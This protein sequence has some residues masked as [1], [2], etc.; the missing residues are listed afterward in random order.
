MSDTNQRAKR[1][2]SSGK[3]SFQMS[4]LY[5]NAV[6]SIRGDGESEH[7]SID[8]MATFFSISELSVSLSI[9]VVV[10]VVVV[11][12]APYESRSENIIKQIGRYFIDQL[13]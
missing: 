8:E 11:V 4:F 13:N 12:V 9:V 6:I 10:V 2:G 3:S 1:G 5:C 7:T